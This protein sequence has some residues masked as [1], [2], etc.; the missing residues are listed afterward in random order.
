[1]SKTTILVIGI[2][3]GLLI[4]LAIDYLL[5]GTIDPVTCTLK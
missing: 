3:V 1:M 4:P 5:F 2:V